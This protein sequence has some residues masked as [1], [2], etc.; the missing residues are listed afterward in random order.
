MKPIFIPGL[1]FPSTIQDIPRHSTLVAWSYGGLFAMLFCAL[2]PT[3]CKKLI[4]FNTTPYFSAADNWPG[5]TLENQTKLSALLRH[6]PSEFDRY[7]LA[8]IQH[9]TRS[10]TLKK[11]LKTHYQRPL[12]NEF[13]ALCQT[14]HRLAFQAL[15][16]P[17]T[18]YLAEK[19]AILPST[20]LAT[21]LSNLNPKVNISLVE[22]ASHG[23][24]LEHNDY[25]S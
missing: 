9:P 15:T 14:D 21:T 22:N 4:L 24:F 11:L 23:H 8:L 1:G 7:F 13:A 20:A 18:L 5:I 12:P 25:F 17:T 19:D 10:L 3:Y 6:H 16:L 2:F